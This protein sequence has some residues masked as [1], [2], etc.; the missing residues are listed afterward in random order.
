[1]GVDFGPWLRQFKDQVE[2]NWLV[3]QAAMALKGHVVIQFAVLRNGTIVGLHVV[4]PS[5][6]DAFTTSAANAL[7]L[8]N[9]TAA[10]PSAYPADQAVIT[11]TF[12]YNEIYH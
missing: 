3:P 7:K 2:R 4:Q 12:H 8:S 6:I 1:M 10:L 9:P 11:V 5:S